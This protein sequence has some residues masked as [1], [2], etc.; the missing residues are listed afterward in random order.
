ML[1]VH[2]TSLCKLWTPDEVMMSLGKKSGS[3]I[4]QNKNKKNYPTQKPE[5]VA[6]T[7][8]LSRNAKWSEVGTE[9]K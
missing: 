7:L 6:V 8:P 3:R 9:V 1:T 5:M 4:H 2:K